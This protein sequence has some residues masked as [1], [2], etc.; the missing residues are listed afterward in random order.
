MTIWVEKQLQ[1]PEPQRPDSTIQAARIN[2]GGVVL[3]SVIGAVATI[4]AAL[5]AAFDTRASVDGSPKPESPTGVI[6]S[7][8]TVGDTSQEP[9]AS[10]EQ[11]EPRS[12]DITLEVRLALDEGVDVDAGQDVARPVD[13]A[14]GEI[15]VFLGGGL[16]FA[17]LTVSGD[18]VYAAS[19]TDIP[20]ANQAGARCPK[21]VANSTPSAHGVVPVATVSTCFVTSERRVAFLTIKSAAFDGSEAVVQVRAWDS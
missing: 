2:R 12:A 11:E 5:I 19:P 13:G 8:S 7:P 20:P 21:V 9:Q 3:V 1:R 15:D 4:T 18:G 14:T 10:S 16:G 17:Q 6:E